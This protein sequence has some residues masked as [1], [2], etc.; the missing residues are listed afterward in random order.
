MAGERGEWV[1]EV[2]P[3]GRTVALMRTRTLI[4]IL[5]VLGALLSS[6]YGALFALLDEVRDE[7]GINESAL[8]LVIGIGFFSS[9][10]AQTTIA[11]LADRGHAR[12]LVML[13]LLLNGA[14]LGLM[15]AATTVLPLLLGRFVM[16]LG[17]GIALPAIRRVAICADP[18]NLGRN[19]GLLLSADIA[20]FAAG[21]PIAAILVGPFGIAGAFAATA[22]A[23]IAAIPFV[24]KMSV[25]ESVAPPTQ[26][27]AFDLL[28]SRS[29]AGAVALGCG[30]FL[31]IGA[32]DALWSIA[33]DDLGTAEWIATLGITMFAL[34][35]IVLGPIGG[36]LAQRIG[37]F[38]VGTAG[39]LAGAVFMMLYGLVPTG[40]AMFAVAMV[41]SLTD[42]LSIAS[43]GVAVGLVVPADRQA[44]AQGV[45][46][47]MQTLVAGVTAVIAGVLY[48]HAGR[49]TAYTVCAA[50]M[51]AC[52]LLART[53]AG[54]HFAMR[55]GAPPETVASQGGAVI[56]D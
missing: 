16:G 31:M 50:L 5:G 52:V 15:A 33:L 6:G 46:G 55:G 2:A 47:G 11:P 19:L 7:Y 48:D 24:A 21:P 54:A 28:R 12:H 56:F 36:R 1:A 45:L 53:L 17:I 22:V 4:L 41:H 34:P 51:L 40:V 39:L 26:R 14:A 18:P 37:P 44:G 23:S 30:V 35:L 25:A 20:G 3:V 10:L 13:G 43:N 9:F 27:F 42:G 32:F 29:F 38:R 8:G 49:A